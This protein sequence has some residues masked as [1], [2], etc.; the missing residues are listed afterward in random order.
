[1]SSEQIKQFQNAQEY[2][3]FK[4]DI[5]E[6]T[7]VKANLQGKTV[8]EIMGLSNRKETLGYS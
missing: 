1:M 4:A 6:A 2:K 7:D 5:T 3:E 8:Q